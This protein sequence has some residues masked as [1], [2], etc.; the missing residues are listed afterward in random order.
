MPKST[1]KKLA[2]QTAYE[3]TP[4]EIKK[5][6]ARNRARYAALKSGKVHKGDN[7]DVAHKTALASGG[8]ANLS[9]TTIQTEKENRGWRKGKS[10]ADS[11]KVPKAK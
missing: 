1:A 2:Y 11:Y 6:E 5:R 9:N 3:N 4:E 8:S 7:K 10:G